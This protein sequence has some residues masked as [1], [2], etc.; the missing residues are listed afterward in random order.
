MKSLKSLIVLGLIVMGST[1]SFAQ[2]ERKQKTP[3]EKAQ[4]MTQKMSE[5]LSLSEEQAAEL[6]GVNIQFVNDLMAVKSD[7]SMEKE[8]KKA[9][10]SELK[11]NHDSKLK[12]ILT[13]EQYTQYEAAAE[14]KMAHREEKKR[15]SKLP[16]KERAAE[17]TQKMTELLDDLTPEQIDQIS[18]LN[19]KV[20]AKIEAIKSDDSMS[21][22]KKREFI[23][24]NRKDQMAVLKTILTEAQM[25]QYKAAKKGAHH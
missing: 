2:E 14:E 6:E 11:T 23:K 17:Q 20:E 25:Q 9:K 5:N 24:G 13:E 7:E 8:S 15:V 10:L 4:R 19:E 21:K 12:E 3:E 18:A 16:A 1:A 22:E